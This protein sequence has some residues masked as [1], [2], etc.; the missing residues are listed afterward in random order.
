MSVGQ[1]IPR[2]ELRIC[3][4]DDTP[5]PDGSIGHIHIRGENVTAAISGSG[6][7]AATLHA[8]TA[9]CARATLACCL[10]G[11]SLHHRSREGDHFRQWPELLSP[12]PRDHR[13]ACAGLELG[14]V[15]VAGVRLPKAQTDHLVLFVL[16]RSKFAG[17]PCRLPAQ[18]TRVVNEQTGPGSIAGRSREAHSE[19][20]QWQDSAPPP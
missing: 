6:D 1:P 4:D 12:R 20:H 2:C 14:K 16:H 10:R 15:V 11:E 9:G 5:L 19:D 8:L 13:P 18:V 17:F 7:N 3:A